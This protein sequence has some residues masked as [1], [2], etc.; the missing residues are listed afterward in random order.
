MKK[1]IIIAIAALL[2]LGL[3]LGLCQMLVVPK[4][5]DNREG[6]LISEYYDQRGGYDVLFVGDCE[7]Y[8][9]FVPPLLWD[10]YGISSYVRGSAQQLPWQSYHILE[11][12]FRYGEKRGVS[13]IAG[14]GQDSY[15]DAVHSNACK[16]FLLNKT[17][18][19][20]GGCLEQQKMYSSSLPYNIQNKPL[21]MNVGYF[22]DG[23]SER[24][25]FIPLSERRENDA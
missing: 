18:L 1:R 6:V 19:H 9:S 12:T 8:E 21:D 17:I 14:F 16:T 2:L 4:Y 22:F 25:I 7:V 3:L 23:T 10:K 24:R 15:I 20:M 11:E 5:A 13:F